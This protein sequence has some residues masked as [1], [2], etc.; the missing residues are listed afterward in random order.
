GMAS[1]IAV[2]RTKEFGIRKVLGASVLKLLRSFNMEFLLLILIANAVAWPLC[3]I[4]VNKWLENFA[5]RIDVEI[6]TFILGAAISLVITLSAVS[7]QALKAS[8]ANPVKCL[9]SE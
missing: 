2:Y 9:R 1:L 4:A 6:S 8:L 3:Y 5:Y 7:I